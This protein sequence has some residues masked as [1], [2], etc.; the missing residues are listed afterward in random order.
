[1]KNLTKQPI[2]LRKNGPGAL[3]EH[4]LE[5]EAACTIRAPY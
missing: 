3:K 2:E 5:E 1:M 4:R